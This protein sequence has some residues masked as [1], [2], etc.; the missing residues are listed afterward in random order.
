MRRSYIKNSRGNLALPTHLQ[1]RLAVQGR[2]GVIRAIPCT[3]PTL[4]LSRE[5]L[6]AGLQPYATPPPRKPEC[7]PLWYERRCAVYTDAAVI[8]ERDGRPLGWADMLEKSRR[9]KP[10]GSQSTWHH[11]KPSAIHSTPW[12]LLKPRVSTRKDQDN[13][14]SNNE[15]R[16]MRKVT[17][18]VM[19]SNFD[20]GCAAVSVGGKE[21]CSNVYK[22]LHSLGT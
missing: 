12:G 20:R 22:Q 13:L 15:S 4:W 17:G 2:D 11:D 3:A 18:T 16:D 10:E 8:G 21:D 19:I 14:G 6:K 7:S 9:V 1:S 5:V